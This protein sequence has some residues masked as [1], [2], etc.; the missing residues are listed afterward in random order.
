MANELTNYQ[1]VRA[2]YQK[3]LI[4]GQ[5]YLDKDKDNT[6]NAGD[7]V[8][9]DVTL[10]LRAG[11][12]GGAV[13]ATTMSDSSGDYTFTD[14]PSGTYSI[15]TSSVTGAPLYN[16][17]SVLVSFA[18]G[19]GQDMIKNIGFQPASLSL[20]LDSNNLAFS[21]TPTS[22]GGQNSGFVTV[23]TTTDNPTG[24]ELTL[25]TSNSNL[26]CQTN[27]S[28]IIPGMTGTGA[29]QT[30]TWGYSKVLAENI[31]G[32]TPTSWQAVPVAPAQGTL[33]KYNSPTTTGRKLELYVG[34]KV[35]L[36]LPACDYGGV[37]TI[38]AV[39]GET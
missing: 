13:L 20:A 34:A 33:E 21:V 30:N 37:V 24:Y 17:E 25:S 29:L 16:T 1:V 28:Y 27:S 8:L 18:L 38:T 5:V 2:S 39:V 10:S 14:L 9:S 22:S 35:N 6:Y 4:V 31:G 36:T 12:S 7:D 15:T 3:A 19:T 32:S 23:T 11:D 26:V